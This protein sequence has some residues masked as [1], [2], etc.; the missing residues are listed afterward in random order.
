MDVD[1]R[2]GTYLGVDQQ[3]DKMVTG[4]QFIGGPLDGEIDN[5]NVPLPDHINMDGYIYRRIVESSDYEYTSIRKEA[6]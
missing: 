3:E 6:P 1:V 5:W 4:I 2:S